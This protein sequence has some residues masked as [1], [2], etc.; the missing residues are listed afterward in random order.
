MAQEADPH[1]RRLG[2][3]VALRPSRWLNR[4]RQWCSGER[5]IRVSR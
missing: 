3:L 1:S 2:A 5:W 4:P